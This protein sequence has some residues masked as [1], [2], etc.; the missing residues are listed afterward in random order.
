MNLFLNAL[1]KNS[2][3][4]LFN[5]NKEILKQKDFEIMWNESEKLI[6]I[7]DDFLSENNT[8]Y[9][10][11][12]NIVVVAG[13]GSFTGVRTIVL[14]INTINFVIKKNI[15]SLN[16]FDLFDTYPII[17]KSSK[18]DSFVKKAKESK[19]EIILNTDIKDYLEKQNI[20]TIY[21]E[22]NEDFFDYLEISSIIDYDKV[23]KNINFD[24]KK[25]IDPIYIKKPSI[26]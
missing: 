25:L 7:I 18:R 14:L 24:T 10:D 11:L 20:K 4:I 22:V 16:F 15:T 26:S 5:E 2:K 12:E 1:T 19:I 3:L 8:N 9:N 17:K 21:W 13:P 6:G 23:I